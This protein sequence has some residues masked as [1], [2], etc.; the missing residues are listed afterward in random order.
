MDVLL[1]RRERRKRQLLRRLRLYTFLGL[2]FAVFW[3]IYYLISETALFQI[4]KINFR[5][6]EK[7]TA[8]QILP[9]IIIPFYQTY[10]AQFFGF[11]NI[12]LWPEGAL[13]S[14]NPLLENIVIQKNIWQKEINIQINER[15]KEGLWCL[16]Q[17][18][19]ATATDCFWFDKNGIAFARAPFGD[20]EL[21]IRIHE[22]APAEKT[23][24]PG[25][26]LLK[27]EFFNHL[28]QIIEQ[29]KRDFSVREIFWQEKNFEITAQIP[30][31]PKL[32]FN[33]R[34]DPTA[35]LAALRKIKE[36]ENL[37]RF[38]YI[39]LRVQNRIFYR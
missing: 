28:Q 30:N 35:N 12:F 6:Q 21:I 4:K 18:P 8:G 33:V 14:K 27:K 39:D 36:K 19:T 34:F 24:H 11:K 2:T 31:G 25:E 1:S 29:L 5:G 32:F 38:S 3:G 10:P 22:T 9:E 20:G 37:K 15:Q 13:F 16:F 23:I 7:T 17:E 26:L